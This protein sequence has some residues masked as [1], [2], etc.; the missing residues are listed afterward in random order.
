MDKKTI[1]IILG[2]IGFV[3]L[4]GGIF[5]GVFLVSKNQDI[6]EKA[7]PATTLSL[8]PATQNKAVG[9]SFALTVNA[10]SGENKITGIDIEVTFNP[11]VVQMNQMSATSAISKL[12]TVIKNGEINNTTG[13]ARFVAFTASKDNAVSG[14]LDIITLSGTIISSAAQGASQLT[15][16]QSST[17]AATDEGVNVIINSIPATITVV[18]S[19]GNSN[20]VSPTATATAIPTATA[21]STTASRTSTPTATPTL[22]PGGI[23]GGT[24]PTAT[25]TTKPTTTATAKSVATSVPVPVTGVSLPFVGGVTLGVGAILLSLFLAF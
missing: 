24:S 18:S 7:A 5:A 10:N 19:N 25:A 17:V 12:S 6:R 11:A 1:G 23:G 13:K 14:S 20:V 4:A 2:I 9:E 3:V 15:F 8:F 21:T 22:A 16:S